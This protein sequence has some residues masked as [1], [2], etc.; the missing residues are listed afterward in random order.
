MPDPI[1]DYASVP[2][3]SESVRLRAVHGALMSA[4][5]RNATP[6]EALE[7]IDM[8][9]LSDVASEIVGRPLVAAQMPTTARRDT[10]GRVRP[11]LAQPDADGIPPGQHGH[12]GR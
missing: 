5:R 4:K 7:F 12:N 10:I 2:S 8:L 11:A 3:L 1:N 6:A 9:G